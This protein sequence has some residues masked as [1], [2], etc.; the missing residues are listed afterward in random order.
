MSESLLDDAMWQPL[1]LMPHRRYW[2]GEALNIVEK[3]QD[4]SQGWLRSMAVSP[5]AGKR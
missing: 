2:R 3:E 5:M 4:V 1:P